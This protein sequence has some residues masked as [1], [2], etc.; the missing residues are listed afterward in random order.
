M[1]VFE[2]LPDGVYRWHDRFLLQSTFVLPDGW[3]WYNFEL[4][5]WSSDLALAVVVQV[6]AIR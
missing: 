3:E 6:R 2:R 5:V 1:T 4:D